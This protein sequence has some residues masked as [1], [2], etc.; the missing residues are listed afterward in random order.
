ML[1]FEKNRIFLIDFGLSKFYI[2]NN[3]NKNKK[4][5]TTA[6]MSNDTFQMQKDIV[7]HNEMVDKIVPDERS[8]ARKRKNATYSDL[9]DLIEPMGQ[10]QSGPDNG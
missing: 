3:Q 6:S 9:F 7:H 10:A 2:K 8:V 5:N 4:Q 1:N